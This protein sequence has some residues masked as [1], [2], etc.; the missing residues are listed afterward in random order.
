[1]QSSR[2]W[3]W[4]TCDAYIYRYACNAP[5]GPTLHYACDAGALHS[6]DI[7]LRKVAVSFYHQDTLKRAVLTQR[8]VSTLKSVILPSRHSKECHIDTRMDVS[9]L[10]RSWRPIAANSQQS[11]HNCKEYFLY[12]YIWCIFSFRIYF[13]FCAVVVFIFLQNDHVGKLE[14]VWRNKLKRVGSYGTN[15]LFTVSKIVNYLFS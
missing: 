12:T 13:L 4:C 8:H 11:S 3:G 14:V 7:T 6:I 2:L 9:N 5:A 10:R 1:M 15:D